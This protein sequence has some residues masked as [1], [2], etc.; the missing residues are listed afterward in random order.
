M[1][2]ELKGNGAKGKND[3]LRAL[4]D[5]SST[6]AP[7]KVLFGGD[8]WVQALPWGVLACSWPFASFAPI[9]P[10]RFG[11]KSSKLVI[12]ALFALA[13]PYLYPL[14][15]ASICDLGVLLPSSPLVGHFATF[16]YQLHAPRSLVDHWSP[17]FL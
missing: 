3:Y 14:A 5:V 8:V 15:L 11:G 6:L 16:A 9:F 10:S 2:S 1:K 7:P 17:F 13:S 12:F 4:G